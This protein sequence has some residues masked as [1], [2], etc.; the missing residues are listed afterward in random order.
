MSYGFNWFKTYKITI[1]RGTA[2]WDY[3]DKNLEYIGGDSTSH[4]GHNIELVQDLIEKYSG[5]RIPEIEPDWIKS[6]DEDL[7]LIEPKEMSDICQRI[8]DETEVDE[9]RMRERIEWF[10]QLSDE[11]YYLSY[12]YE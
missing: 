10:K 5:K 9:V 1:N 6:E 3:D 7:H 12:D 4:S 8:L 2:M 11:G